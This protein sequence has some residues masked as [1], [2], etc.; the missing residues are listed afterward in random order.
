MK[1]ETRSRRPGD[2]MAKI[3]SVL[4]NGPKTMEEIIRQ[5]PRATAYRDIR[6]LEK[7][8]EVTQVE[9]GDDQGNLRVLYSLK[10]TTLSLSDD[11]VHEIL[12][13]LRSTSK[14]VRDEALRD[15]MEISKKRRIIDEDILTYLI[16]KADTKSSDTI[17]AIL[18][19]QAVHATKHGDAAIMELLRSFTPKALVIVKNATKPDS[20][21]EEA[22]RFLQLTADFDDISNLA[23]EITSKSSDPALKPSQQPTQF[24]II[25]QS[26]C[27][28]AARLTVFRSKIYDLL[29]SDDASVVTRAQQILSLSREP[30][31][32]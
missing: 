23:I 27:V 16:T 26:I 1:G 3:R 32:A 6:L 24:A 18:V 4:M 7:S 20:E 28:R 15:I 12:T 17:M 14:V 8:G 25:V 29:L 10:D 13:Q 19:S 21:R 5:V 30:G 31:L 11:M 2:S 9:E 22:L